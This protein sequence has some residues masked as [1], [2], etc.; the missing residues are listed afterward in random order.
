MNE[1]E[2]N[3]IV[4]AWI[5]GQDAEDATP[6]DEANWWAFSQVMDWVLKG[7]ADLLWQFILTTY[8]RDV[9]D[10]VIAALAAGPLED[11]LA[12]HGQNYIDQVE[13]LAGRDERFNRLLGGVWRNSMTDASWDLVQSA[14]QQVW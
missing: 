6:A 10:R 4:D 14:R 13:Q 8:K 5:A 11:L 2:M 12:K 7:E 1:R 9:S 3:R